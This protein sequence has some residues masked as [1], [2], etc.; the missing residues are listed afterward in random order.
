MFAGPYARQSIITTCQS[1]HLETGPVETRIVPKRTYTNTQ[2]QQI[3]VYKDTFIAEESRTT[4]KN[5]NCLIKLFHQ[6]I[7]P[8]DTLKEALDNLFTTVATALRT[9]CSNY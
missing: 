6:T 3:I 2:S 1:S 4:N 7:Q 8:K 9:C 5:Y